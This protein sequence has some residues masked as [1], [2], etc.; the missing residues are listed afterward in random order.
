MSK[1]TRSKSSDDFDYSQ[2]LNLSSDEE[3]GS[4]KNTKNTKIEVDEGLF[5]RYYSIMWIW[6]RYCP[7]VE[8]RITPLTEMI[9]YKQPLPYHVKKNI[10]ENVDL[11]VIYNLCKTF[12]LSYWQQYEER[13]VDEFKFMFSCLGYPKIFPTKINSMEQIISKI[14]SFIDKNAV[15][16]ETFNTMENVILNEN[17]YIVVDNMFSGPNRAR[18]QQIRAL[19]HIGKVRY[20]LFSLDKAITKTKTTENFLTT[21]EGFL[22][23]LDLRGYQYPYIAA[24]TPSHLRYD[25]GVII[26]LAEHGFLHSKRDTAS[27]SSMSI[28]PQELFEDEDFINHI[29]A[30]N[31]SFKD[32]T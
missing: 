28:I 25:K 14:T 31:N 29:I 10:S 32:T 4:N 13:F 30:I 6:S 3:V 15:F 7:E 23:L 16:N 26:A 22:L 5:A 24:Y 17:D 19:L 18:S 8:R 1:R 11:S 2:Y 9:T 21:K 12:V 20:L 27:F